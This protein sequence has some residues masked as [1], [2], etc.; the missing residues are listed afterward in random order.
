M[1]LNCLL[2]HVR[3]ADERSE[4]LASQF[5]QLNTALI[6]MLERGVLG[7]NT[8]TPARALPVTPLVPSPVTPSPPRFRP[9]Q[10][11]PLGTFRESVPD[12]KH[13]PKNETQFYVSS[14]PLIS[15][16][17]TRMLGKHESPHSRIAPQG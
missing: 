8:G 4:K 16:M 1:I 5:D 14:T 15:S 2:E 17:L 6:T 13:K 11:G 12:T 3:T 9:R 10:N 7:T